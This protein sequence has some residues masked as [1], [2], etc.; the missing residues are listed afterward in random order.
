VDLAT[1]VAGGDRREDGVGAGLQQR[2]QAQLR[3]AGVTAR[4]RWPAERALQIRQVRHVERRPVEAD[5]AA[6]AVPGARRARLGQRPGEAPEQLTHRGFAQAHPGLGDRRLARQAQGGAVPVQPA[7]SLHQFPQH[8]VVGGVGIECQGHHVVDHDA[9]QQLARPPCHPPGVP[10]HRIHHVGRDEPGQY[11]Q[12]HMLTK[13]LALARAA[14][15]PAHGDPPLSPTAL[16]TPSTDQAHKP[17][18]LITPASR[19]CS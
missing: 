5:Q 13:P 7:Q 8:R 9:R 6:P 12:R 18:P 14:S 15:C 4:S 1:R 16:D 3:E 10:Q 19:K 11:P 2:Q 17:S